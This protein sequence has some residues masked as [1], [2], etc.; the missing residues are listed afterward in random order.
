MENAELLTKDQ[1]FFINEID[2][3][4]KELSSKQMECTRLKSALQFYADKNHW[5]PISGN[6]EQST[7]LCAI[8]KSGRNGYDTA[9]AIL[10]AEKVL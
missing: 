10:D 1:A 2:R 8:G 4:N 9:A 6:T 3:L 5:M 7:V